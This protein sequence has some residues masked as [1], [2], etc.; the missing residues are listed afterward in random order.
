[1]L[2]LMTDNAVCATVSRLSDNGFVIPA[3]DHGIVRPGIFGNLI[4]GAFGAV[5]TWGLYEDRNRISFG[6][7]SETSAGRP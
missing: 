3:R 1:M 7:R 4:L 6:D 5:V 2:S